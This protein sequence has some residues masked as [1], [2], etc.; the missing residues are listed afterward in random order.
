VGGAADPDDTAKSSSPVLWPATTIRPFGWSAT[1]L[2]NVAT[3][4]ST[5]TLPATPNVVSG[6]PSALMRATATSSSACV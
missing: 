4:K 2:P 5:V 6:D 3:P 1:A